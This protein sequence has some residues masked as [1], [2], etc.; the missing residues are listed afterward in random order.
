M[1]QLEFTVGLASRAESG[2]VF[3]ILIVHVDHISTVTV[4]Y[5]KA[6]P[7]RA[8]RD[9]CRLKDIPLHARFEV[10]VLAL[11]VNA[12][13]HR[14][15]ALPDRL[16]LKSELCELFQSLVTGD[17]EKLLAVF[18]MH[19]EAMPTA[20]KLFPERADELTVGIE[21]ENGRVILLIFVA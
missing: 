17:V 21:N 13:F 7:V 8:E 9:V 6:F 11:R 14:R 15:V 12:R 19:L 10:S 2:F 20:L 5:V 16:A 3:R 1:R 4:G 18:F